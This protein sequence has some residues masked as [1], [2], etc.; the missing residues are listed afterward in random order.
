MIPPTSTTPSST[1]EGSGLR[2]LIPGREEIESLVRLAFPVAT[3]QVG[4]MAMGVVDTLMVGRVSAVDLA[5]VALGHIYFF[6]VTVFGIGVLMALD[7]LVSQG[8]A[9]G[10]RRAVKLAVQRGL[11]L[12]VGLALF[13]A[14][15]L[16][17]G[18]PL[19]SLLSQPEEVVPVAAGYARASIPGVFP[20]FAFVVLRQS[21]QAMGRVS[22]IVWTI[23]AANLA[24]LFFNW[25][26]IFG[27][28]GVP[29]MGAVGSGW[30]SSLARWLMAVGLLAA[31]WPLLRPYLSSLEVAALRTGPMARMLKLG[32]PIGIQFE[33]EF[34]AFAVVAIFM[35]WLGTVAMAG[36]QVAINLASL[37]F[38]VPLGISQASAVLVGQAVGRDSPPEARRAGGAGLLLGAGFM[39]L[40]GVLFLAAPGVL[41]GLYSSEPEVVTLAAVLIPIAGVFQVFDGLQVVATG[42][43]RGVGDTRAPMLASVLGFWVVGVPV[44]VLFGFVWDGGPVGLWWG[45]VAGLA[46]VAAF[47]LLRVRWRFGG[48]LTRIV[49]EEE[50]ITEEQGAAAPPGVAGPGEIAA[51]GRGSRT[52][53][54][55]RG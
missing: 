54:D 34:G 8:F 36:H 30:A 9:S 16:F 20:F 44:S 43:L 41:A 19:L 24:N 53:G 50:G 47:L 46:A 7:P 42:V 10:D 14:V 38:M 21:L 5:A 12:S 27:N 40:T 4:M 52:S 45:L 17:P 23:V 48:D 1:S 51:R 6:S 55:P 29:A 35:G 18:E 39:T 31:A 37:T 26:F 15:V 25:I 22:P 2:T 28:L 49:L 32:L 3:V 13:V 11:L 33:L